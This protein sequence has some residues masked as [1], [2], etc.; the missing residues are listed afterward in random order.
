MEGP[1][2]SRVMLTTTDNPY[3]PFTEWEAWYGY[4]VAAGHHTASFL[5]RITTTSDELSEVDQ[6]L[7]VETAIDEIVELNIT[8]LYKKVSRDPGTA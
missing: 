6:A 5:A 1:M 8:G 2:A 4:D 7:A 3:D